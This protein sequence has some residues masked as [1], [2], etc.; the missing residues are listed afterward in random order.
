M[1]LL[2]RGLGLMKSCRAPLGARGLKHPTALGSTA[3]TG[4]APLGARGLKL[5]N[6]DSSLREVESRPARGAWIETRPAVAGRRPD[7]RAP[8]GARGLKRTDRGGHSG[9]LCRA[10][11]G[12]RGLKL[13]GDQ[14]VVAHGLSRPARG[15]WIETARIRLI[16]SPPSSRPARGAWIETGCASARCRDP[17]VA[18]RSGRV[19]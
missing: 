14:P 17:R 2:S 12:A 16:G 7:R 10:P 3:W 6:T 15:A 11:L 5:A 18:P 13:I 9:K 19:D 4:R 8:L 1:K